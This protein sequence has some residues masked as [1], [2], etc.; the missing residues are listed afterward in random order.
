MDAIPCRLHTNFDAYCL[1][2]KRQK[3]LPI[4][5]DVDHCRR[6]YFRQITLNLGF[7]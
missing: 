2:L 1:L 5:Q 3:I 4:K 7:A 6:S